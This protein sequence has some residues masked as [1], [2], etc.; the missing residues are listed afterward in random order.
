MKQKLRLGDSYALFRKHKR[1]SVK[2]LCV[3][4]HAQAFALPGRG[5]AIGI[6]ALLLLISVS[7]NAHGYQF[8]DAPADT[9]STEI[10]PLQIGDTIP[11]SL[12][13]LPLHVVNHPEGKE[14]ITLSDYKDKLIILDFWGTF[15]STCISAMPEVHHVQQQFADSM[16]VLP[17]SWSKP[18]ATEQALKNHK[19]LKPLGLPSIVEAEPLIEAFPHN[20]VPHYAWIDPQGR[21]VATTAGNDVTAGNVA[22]VLRN[23][24]P[25]YALKTYIDPDE[26]LV[27]GIDKFPKSASLR[28]LSTLVHG[29]IPSLPSGSRLRKR[30]NTVVGRSSFNVTIGALYYGIAEKILGSR[31]SDQQVVIAADTAKYPE[32]AIVNRGRVVSDPAKLCSYEFATAIEN[33]DSLYHRMLIDLNTCSGFHGIIEMRKVIC[34]VLKSMTPDAPLKPVGAVGEERPVLQNQSFGLLAHILEKEPSLN[35]RIVLD[36]TGID[37]PATIWLKQGG[38]LQD[39]KHAL[40]AHGLFLEVA[41]RELEFMILTKA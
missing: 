16:I 28:K 35:G 24:Q 7:S 4:T 9:L 25:D 38:S 37:T 14:T 29:Y 41:E 36:E 26:P 3:Q 8:Q 6:L 13:H 31:F 11:E 21:V 33:A 5:R 27:S 15:C 12:W 40:E 22:K 32:I 30:G 1:K 17:V 34:Y 39:L 10:T 19:T 2:K 18:E 20:V 23:E